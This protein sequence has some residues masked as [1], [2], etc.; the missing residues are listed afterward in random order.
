MCQPRFCER[1]SRR[2]VYFFNPFH[3]TLITRS[4]HDITFT[5]SCILAHV[6]QVCLKLTSAWAF[7]G[8]PCVC[9]LVMRRRKRRMTHTR[10]IRNRPGGR[11]SSLRTTRHSWSSVANWCS[12]NKYSRWHSLS[13]IKCK[14]ME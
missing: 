9:Q 1:I 4:F 7:N 5:S 8:K 12:W 6:H 2:N 11:T 10:D 14:C 3:N 13:E